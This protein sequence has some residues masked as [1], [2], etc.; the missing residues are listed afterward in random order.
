MKQLLRNAVTAKL[1]YLNNFL[2]ATRLLFL[3]VM[4]A[5]ATAQTEYKGNALN[6]SKNFM[7]GNLVRTVYYNYGLMGNIGEISGEWPAGTGDEYVGDVSPLV[8]VEFIHPNGDTLHSVTTSDGPRGNPDGPPG[9]GRFW[10]FEPLPGFAATPLAG[11]DPQVAISNDTSTWPDFWPDKMYNDVRDRHWQRDNTDPGWAAAW[12]GY[13]GKNV[14]SADQE[15]YFQMDDQADEEWFER[16]LFNNP[17]T[18]TTW[19]PPTPDVN[20]TITIVYDAVKGTLSDNTPAVTL[21]WGIN[22]QTHDLW[23]LPPQAIWPQGSSVVGAVLQTPMTALGN[24]RFTVSITPN[25]AVGSLHLQFT[26]GTALDDNYHANWNIFLGDGEQTYHFYPSREDSSRRGVGLRVTVRGLQWAHFLAQ[27]CIFWLYDI[28]NISSYTY[29]KVTFGM[30]VGTLSGGRQDSRDD[31]ARFILSTGI[32]YSYDSDDQGSPGWVPVRPGEIN[33]GIVG[34]AFLESPGNPVDGI[35]NDGDDTLGIAPRLDR[36]TLQLMTSPRVIQPN[37]NIILTD[38]D[39]YERTV[40]TFPPD[41]PLR[42]NFRGIEKLVFPGDTLV[43]DGTNGLDDNF[44]GII[45]ERNDT[46]LVGLRYI[47]YFTGA[48]ASDAMLD[49]ARDDGIDND[50]DWNPRKDDV[51]A[52]GV[53]GTRDFGESDG[54][55]TDGEPNFDRTDVDESDQIGLTAFEYFAPPGAVR[56]RDDPGLWFRMIPGKVDTVNPSPEDGDFIYGSGYFPLRPGQTERFS[57]A[58]VYGADLQDIQN[59]EATVQQIYNENYNFAR[60]PDPP[61]VW[62]VPGDG[63]VTLYW[64]GTR[65]ENSIDQVSDTTDFEGYKIYRSTDPRFLEVFTVTD[66]LGNPTFFRPIAQF[67]LDNDW[68]DFY[69]EAVNGLSFYL[70]TNS[71]LQHSWTDHSVENGQTYYYAVC[72][73]DRGDLS[74][75]IF[76]AEND[77]TINVDAAGNVTLDINCAV[78]RPRAP[79]A[80]YT[81]PELSVIQHSVGRATGSFATEVLDPLKVPDRAEYSFNF[82]YYPDTLIIDSLPGDSI[83][84]D[85]TFR[86]LF[87]YALTRATSGNANA[88]TVIRFEP[89]VTERSLL[90]KAAQFAT[91]YDSLFN[92]PLGTYDPREHFNVGTTSIYDGQRS[93]YLVPRDSNLIREFSG[94]ADTTRHQYEFSFDRFRDPTIFLE[95]QRLPAD[96]QIEWYAGV[97]DTSAYLNYYDLRIFQ[98]IPVNFKVHNL[99]L[100]QYIDFLFV[101]ATPNQVV[102][103]GDLIIFFEHTRTAAGADTQIVSWFTGFSFSA[104]NG[105]TARPADGDVLGLF[106]YQGFT[107]AD[108]YDYATRSARVDAN[109]ARLDRIKVYPNPYVAVSAQEPANPFEEGRGERRITFIHLPE[110]CTIRIYN[111][112]GDLVREIEHSAGIDDGQANWDLRSDDGLNVAYGVYLYHVESPYGDK[113]GRFAVVK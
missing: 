42:Y 16:T 102:D 20:Q 9:G 108:Q 22:E 63:Q 76:P 6:R 103:P 26:D 56:M 29:D 44:N 47:D 75:H 69:P 8:G 57:M 15:T 3:L 38:Y 72:A 21:R 39:S 71:G 74:R 52:D 11:E 111:I 97:V 91:Y 17:D 80:G 93:Y 50:H 53:A 70:G 60:P 34:Y 101:D 48:G 7:S 10:G 58:L 113:T 100:D 23:D 41:G 94:W 32:T 19:D 64:D 12:N 61:T 82:R 92:L 68:D 85:T 28:T 81:G 65:S 49:E 2:P 109:N 45:D 87:G 30:V 84:G 90:G 46:T 36:S 31:L 13:F 73:Y 55:P 43:E 88:D 104:A 107:T 40:S 24:G 37:D 33:V 62:A 99:T 89:I 5:A 78:V 1:G 98:P 4:A 95:G 25:S 51:G 18:V 77:K 35:D 86:E 67:D 96:Y 106:I 83:P 105:D 27:D 79:A 66:Y 54:Q 59:N 112:K 14:L 110:R